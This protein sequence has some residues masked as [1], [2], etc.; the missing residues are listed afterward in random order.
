[1]KEIH[2]MYT[3][4]HPHGGTHDSAQ[5]MCHSGA[6]LEG[7]R[8]KKKRNAAKVTN[9]Q[10]MMVCEDL[11]NFRPRICTRHTRTNGPINKEPTTPKQNYKLN[12]THMLS[13]R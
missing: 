13:R 8:A 7:V 10:A 5:G 1:M 11:L 3:T 6:N 4:L 2:A 9:A 12:G